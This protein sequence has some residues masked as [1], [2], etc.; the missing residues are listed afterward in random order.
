MNMARILTRLI[1]VLVLAGTLPSCRPEQISVPPGRVKETE[2]QHPAAP[3]RA[4]QPEPADLIAVDESAMQWP[5]I[6]GYHNPNSIVYDR[7][8]YLAYLSFYANSAT[9]CGLGPLC[10]ITTDGRKSQFRSCIDYGHIGT[11]FHIDHLRTFL[12]SRIDGTKQ[13]FSDARPAGMNPFERDVLFTVGLIQDARAGEALPELNALLSDSNRDI[14]YAAIEAIGSLGADAGDS[15][16]ALGA[17]LETDLAAEA[18]VAL[19]GIGA[20]AIPLL[21]ENVKAGSTDARIFSIEA[22]GTIGPPAGSAV[23][24][25]IEAL[26]E[27]QDATDRSGYISS[28]A[29][30]ALGRIRDE[31]ALR[32]L[33]RMDS[34][35]NHDVRYASQAAIRRIEGEPKP[36]P[37]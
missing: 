12:R 14:R 6:D 28:Y 1:L 20:A 23:E 2:R 35:K 30:T 37:D 16:A 8:R 29:A 10:E 32:H 18:S 21:T 17:V 22:L 26:Y 31:R 11:Q 24:E 5:L 3:V 7:K 25:L 15:V 19:A 33:K 4:E 34:A 13:V 36:A 27:K 9:I